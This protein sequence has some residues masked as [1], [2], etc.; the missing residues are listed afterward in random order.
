MLKKYQDNDLVWIDLELPT[1]EEIRSF[2]NEYKI[3][4]LVASELLSPTLRSRV[5]VY[6]NFIYLILHFPTVIHS[7]NK[8]KEQEVDFIIGK[9]FVITTHYDTVDV[10]HEFS[11]FFEAKSLLEKK[12]VSIH[13]GFLFFYMMRHFYQHMNDELDHLNTSLANIENH[14][15]EGDEHKM[16]HKISEV[17]RQLLNFKKALE[18]H[19]SVLSSFEVAGKKLFGADFEYYLSSISGEHY[20]IKSSLK[21]Y[22]EIL[23]ELRIT[24]DSLLNTKTTDIMR[25]LTI[26]AFVTFPLSLLASLFGMNT[27]YLPIVGT[28]YDFWFIIGIM[29]IA[30]LFFFA[31]FRYKNWL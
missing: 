12:E 28:Q 26:M 30:T 4:P 2:I 31:F 19:S 22:I 29:A 25:V 1:N 5:D 20:K 8:Q 14:I 27:A 11:K 15:F 10:L 18:S 24:N 16:V 3:H 7:H 21:N 23:N 17:S 6:D 9:D 13:G